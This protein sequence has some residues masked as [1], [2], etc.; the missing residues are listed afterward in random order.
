MTRVLLIWPGCEGAAAGNFGVPQLVLLAT[1]L[2]EQT[3]AKVEIRDLACERAFGPIDFAAIVDGDDRKGYDVIA[4]SVYSSFD[5]LKCLALA[6]LARERWP[7]AVMVAGGY[8]ASARPLDLLRDSAGGSAGPLGFDVV[9]VGEGEQP[10][11]DIVESV[12][13]GAPLQGVLGPAA[14]DDLAVLPP[15]DWSFLARYRGIAR[16]VASQAQVYLSRGCP[17]DCAFCMERAKRD[18]SWRPLP[19]ERAVEEIARLHEFLDLRSW[20]LYF[21][22]ALFGMRKSWRR[23]FLEA[24][25][26]KGI[27]VEKY[28]LLIRVELDDDEDLRLF[29]AANC[30]L[31]FGLESGDPGQLAVIR[32]SGRLD[33]Y[34]DR[35]EHIAERSRE[36]DVPWGANVICG[37][38]G[39]TEATLR[40]SAAWLGKLFTQPRGTTGFLSIDPF[41][42][43]PGSPIDAERGYY[44][45]TFGT[46]FHRP[47][48]WDDG[49]PAFLSE[50]VDPSEGLDWATREALQHELLVP[51]LAQIEEHF[52]YR[53]QAREYFL[54]A[55]RE[56]L[57]FARP[58]QRFY[59]YDRYYAWHAYLGRRRQAI[60]QRRTHVALAEQASTLR[61]DVLA[62]VA[63]H[64]AVDPTAR[65]MKAIAEV[66]RERFVPLEHIADSVRDIAVALDESGEATVS[67]MHAYARAFH[68]LD[69]QPGDRVLDLGS[70]SGYGTALL[71]RLV[72]D[73]GRVV[74]V[75]LDPRLV[76]SARAE[77]D[78]HTVELAVGDA[79]DPSQWPA[80][81]RACAK[82]VVGFA[83]PELP[84]AWLAALP[85]GAR[86]VAPLGD[87]EQQRLTVAIHCGDRFECEAL[88]PVRYVLARRHV[89]LPTRV[90]HEPT[91]RREIHLPIA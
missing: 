91:Q 53:G 33:D 46:R 86:V 15:S 74:A 47:H 75:E 30:G 35:M 87:G 64:A 38:P 55:I 24:L 44:E 89:D 90:E 58:R 84:D 48:W 81:A 51:V 39:E 88:E 29:A 70:G 26:R 78:A 71:A 83:M 4:F 12:R 16:R 2:R 11:V 45:R 56:Q 20:T 65:V 73:D 42:L 32:K 72:G 85:H 7:N 60:A 82:V 14:I 34:L 23:Q 61:A 69:V 3:G 27:P 79:V 54:R 22:D 31:G 41:R 63:E 21:G 40:T 25:A 9:V 59:D 19:I 28:W 76:A 52:V 8:H 62:Q 67:A 17:F 6:E 1:Y 66:P 13:G 80:A 10:L 57:A 49:D 37:H 18:T 5:H 77:I 50:W 68:L 43:Y 36:H